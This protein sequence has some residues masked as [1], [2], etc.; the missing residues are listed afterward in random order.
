MISIVVAHAANRVIG[1]GGELP[2]RLPTDMRHFRK[3]TTGGTVLMGRRTFESIP[4]RFRP[5]PERRNL[6]LSRD[7]AYS[8]PGAEVCR[9]LEQALGLCGRDCFVIGGGLTYREALPLCAR[10][11]ATEIDAEIEGDACFPALP[12][13]EWQLIERGDPIVESQLAFRFC[14]YERPA[15]G[16][17]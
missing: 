15:G 2:W 17:R 1:R 6:V 16:G 14:T 9:G 3:L 7:P 10:V 13:A 8:A 12:A 11:Y 4:P 5:L